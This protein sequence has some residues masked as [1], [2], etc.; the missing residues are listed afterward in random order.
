MA[1]PG[2]EVAVL[3]VGLC[4]DAGR[5]TDKGPRMA[6]QCRL[7]QA[8]SCQCPVGRAQCHG[9][10]THSGLP[11]QRIHSHLPTAQATIL[12]SR[13]IAPPDRTAELFATVQ[14][15]RRSGDACKH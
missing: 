9:G 11:L 6:V 3:E 15:C 13:L 10:C 2:R 5:R 8:R 4:K 12:T 14:S 7:F 1:L